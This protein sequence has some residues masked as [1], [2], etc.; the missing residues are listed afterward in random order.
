MIY[1]NVFVAFFQGE[2]LKSRVKKVCA[3]YHAALY[4][5]P[6]NYEEREDM[7]KGVQVRLEDLNMVINQTQDQRNRVLVSVAKDL[8][9]W[10][11]MVK[12]IKAIYHISNC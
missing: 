10:I 5:C 8:P 6:D 1:K 7:L 3:G 4:P 12:K 2:Q 11:I 9:K